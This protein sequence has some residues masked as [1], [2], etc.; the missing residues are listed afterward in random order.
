MLKFSQLFYIC[1]MSVRRL[2]GDKG[3]SVLCT[4]PE[5]DPLAESHMF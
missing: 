4:A 3:S 1:K 2:W 5:L